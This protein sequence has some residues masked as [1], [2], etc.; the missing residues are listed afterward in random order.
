MNLRFCIA[1]VVDVSNF[2]KP[3]KN[4]AMEEKCWCDAGV[5]SPVSHVS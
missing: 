3:V 5:C 4:E 1:Q 2:L